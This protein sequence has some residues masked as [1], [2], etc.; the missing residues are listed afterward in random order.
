M[1]VAQFEELA[2]FALPE[3]V[4]WLDSGDVR[5]SFHPSAIGEFVPDLTGRDRTLACSQFVVISGTCIGHVR[6]PLASA[7]YMQKWSVWRIPES[8]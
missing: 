4:R 2:L 5:L 8:E 6:L 3:S 7:I 1:S